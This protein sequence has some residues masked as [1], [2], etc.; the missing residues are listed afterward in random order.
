MTKEKI[1]NLCKKHKLYVTPRL[2]DVLYLHYQGIYM[3]EKEGVL[4]NEGIY[5]KI[6]FLILFRIYGN[7][8]T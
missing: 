2:N 5:M 8:R 1:I 7:K 6:T 3:S 4:I